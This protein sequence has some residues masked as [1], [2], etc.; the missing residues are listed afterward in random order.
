[1]QP[2][3]IQR[4]KLLFDHFTISISNHKCYIN[5]LYPV[6]DVY[7][8]EDLCLQTMYALVPLPQHVAVDHVLPFA[9]HLY[10]PNSFGL[11]S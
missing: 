4:F 11:V 9:V 5:I 3:Q 2:K 10:R 1:M 7:A 6:P 8:T